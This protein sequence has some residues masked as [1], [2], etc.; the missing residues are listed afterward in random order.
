MSVYFDVNNMK[1]VM[2]MFCPEEENVLASIYAVGKATDIIQYFGGCKS[3]GY[4]LVPTDDDNL[5]KVFKRKVCTYDLY[6]GYTEK[7]LI[8]SECDMATRYF[9]N[10]E[11][12]TTPILIG[13][14]KIEKEITHNSI[15]KVF[16]LESIKEFKMKKGWF[17]SL[18]CV[19]TLDNG[20][21][22]KIMLTKRAGLGNQM[23]EHIK[24]RDKIIEIL[25]QYSK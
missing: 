2:E 17:G 9:Y 25:K 3:E 1:K 4:K 19:L 7:S 14:K 16:L 20:T 21:F 24:N 11:E 23:P 10:I 13:V 12:I 18:N 8:I 6:I 15:G 22:F 5:I